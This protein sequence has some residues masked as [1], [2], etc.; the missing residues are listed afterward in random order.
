MK[1]K[2]VVPI[3]SLQNKN[4]ITNVESH[5]IDNGEGEGG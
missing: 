5:L 4:R 2:K 1:S 3:N